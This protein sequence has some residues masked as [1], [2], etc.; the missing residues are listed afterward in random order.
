MSVALENARL[1]EQESLYR[2]ALEREFEIG[3]EIQAGFLPRHLPQIT[4]W[5]VAASLKSARE[6]AGDFYDVFE[7]PHE[8]LGLVIGDV[9]D[10]GLGAALF[11]TLFSS[12]IRAVSNNDFF[13]H[14][15][16]D[17]TTT[18]AT[19]LMNA[20]TLTNSYI[21]E[22]HGDTGM[23][24]TVFFGIL[25]TATG[26]LTYINAGHLPPLLVGGNDAR[27]NLRR[28]GPAV[29]IRA[30]AAYTVGETLIGKGES[31]F[32]HTDGLTDTT[33]L[34]GR[35]FAEG[36]LIALLG[37]NPHLSLSSLLRLIEENVDQHAD[38][39]RQFDD[40]TMLAVRRTS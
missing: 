30:D 8:Q 22:T 33:D 21:V 27:D 10:K 18:P 19:R 14:L 38:G 6:V 1:W 5:E 34:A 23:F 25:D 32:A 29:G 35:F 28:T 11:M 7:L 24:A 13:P 31:L 36:Q 16:S 40:I 3:R 26:T 12:L 39:C 20:I 37:A 4:G 2:K 15:K 17:F 9:C